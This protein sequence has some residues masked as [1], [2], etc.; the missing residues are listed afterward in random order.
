[1]KFI[2]HKFKNKENSML[3]LTKRYKY[4]MKGNLSAVA[5]KWE[6]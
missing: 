4:W 5:E 1:M 3:Y 6:N 2:I